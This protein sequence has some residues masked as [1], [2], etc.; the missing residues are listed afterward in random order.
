MS[1]STT[2]TNS[3]PVPGGATP[4]IWE[5]E[6]PSRVIHRASRA[7]IGRDDVL[8]GTTAIHFADGS[9]DD[10]SRVESPHG[11]GRRAPTAGSLPLRPAS[12]RPRSS[13]AP[14]TLT[15]QD[16]IA[17]RRWATASGD[18]CGCTKG[19]GIKNRNRWKIERAGLRQG[20]H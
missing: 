15:G 11:Y 10:G 5:G 20:F 19:A 1:S 14:T 18:E 12:L 7:I 9:V 4:D 13:S 17:A 2:V 8:V 3:V 6:Q 16:R